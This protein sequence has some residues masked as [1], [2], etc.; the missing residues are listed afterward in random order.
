[1][2]PTAKQ[3]RLAKRHR[4]L[5]LEIANYILEFEQDD[6]YYYC[7]MPSKNH[8]YYKAYLFINGDQLA[9]QMLKEAIGDRDA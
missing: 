3:V 5:G 6:F 2:I 7:D 1:M 4:D 8:V 9:N